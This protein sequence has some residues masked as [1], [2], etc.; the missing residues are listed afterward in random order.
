MKELG[1][2]LKNDN[3]LT[4]DVDLWGEI[5]PNAIKEVYG[6]DISFPEICEKLN[7]AFWDYDYFPVFEKVS[8]F[9]DFILGNSHQA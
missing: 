9:A 1:L 6:G 3:R 8:D 7:I 4:K 2:L 5:V